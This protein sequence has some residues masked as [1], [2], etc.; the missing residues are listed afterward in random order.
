MKKT[1]RALTMSPFGQLACTLLLLLL[2]SLFLG[3][4]VLA[5]CPPACSCTRSHRV[6][7]CSNRGLSQLPDGLQHNIWALNLSRNGLQDLN[8]LLGHF[9]HLRTLDI[10]Y[11]QFTRLPSGLPRAL[12]EILASGNQFRMLE[13]NDTAYHWNLQALDLSGNELERM[14]FIN[15]TLP[16]LR[17]LNL[18][19]NKFWTV[20]TNMPSNVETVDLSNNFLVQI[21]P[22]SLDRLP[23]LSRFYLHGNRFSVVGEQTFARLDGLRLITLD[24]NPWACE[25]E[26]NITGLL[27]W[28]HGTSARVVGCP[29]H[30]RPICGEARMVSTGAWRFASYT[31][32]PPPWSAVARDDSRR[33]PMEDK[34]ESVS[35]GYLSNSAPLGLPDNRDS[36]HPDMNGTSNFSSLPA[37]HLLFG[38]GAG[39]GGSSFSTVSTATSTTP[40]ARKAKKAKAGGIRS[41]TNPGLVARSLDAV[42]LNILLMATV[43]S[44]F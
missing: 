23:R 42:V 38:G 16:E 40:Q 9:S 6:V 15:N 28:M 31:L 5:V 24:D 4:G 3:L 7:D 14:V 8:G 43:F 18:S 32:P 19:H 34:E 13:K 21:L 35:W 1:G 17:L 22:G 2:L 41:S 29:C 37:G 12:W 27:T 44:V 25:D 36:L 26:E 20:P 30:T 39:G 33:P 10:S 11:N